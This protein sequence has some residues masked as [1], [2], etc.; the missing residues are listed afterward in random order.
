MRCV[1]GIRGALGQQQG[2]WLQRGPEAL[3][4]NESAGWRE[5]PLGDPLG[6][7]LGG[8]LGGLWGGPESPATERLK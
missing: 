1:G 3:G 7:L 4:R 2:A 5:R 8:P 6:D